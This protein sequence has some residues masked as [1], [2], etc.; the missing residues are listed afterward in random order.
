ML[1]A[2]DVGNTN[3]VLGVFEDAT[4]AES[5]RLA[6]MH[7]R[8][9]DEFRVLVGR[10]FEERHI[11]LDRVTGVVLSSVVPPLTRTVTEMIRR[12]F[13]RDALIVDAKNAGMPIR[14]ENPEEVG[15]DRLVNGVAAFALYGNQLRPIIVVDFGTATT[16]DAISARGEYLGGVICPGV[17]ISADALFQ[18]AARLPRVEVRKPERLIGRTTVGSMQAGLFFGYVAMV[19]GIVQRLRAELAEGDRPAL[20]VATGGLAGS[21]AGETSAIDLIKVDLTLQ[22]LR[23]VWERNQEGAGR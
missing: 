18:R 22:G 23:L 19:E 1:L 3:I 6:T 12:S 10:L 2:I 7:E 21:M 17:E 13:G 14:Y 11:G 8:T 16:F 9:A 5:W 15:A 4:L 20:C